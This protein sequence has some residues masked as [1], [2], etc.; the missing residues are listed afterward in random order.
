M[1]T[2]KLFLLI[3]ISIAI[4]SCKKGDKGDLGPQG[5]AGTTGATGA[6]GNANA[7][8]ETISISSSG[9]QHIG[10]QGQVGDGQEAIKSTSIITSDIV[11]GGAVLAF[12][13]TGNLIWTSLP[14][15]DYFAS[16]HETWSYVYETGQITVRIN[17][18]DFIT[19]SPASTVYLKVVVI[20][21][22]S[23]PAPGSGI[24]L[25]NY[26]QV[27]AYYHLTD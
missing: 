16:Y 14:T 11:S 18:S 26:E 24:D 22:H 8:T 10:T 19:L 23:R 21:G 17:D 6:T 3:A 4:V 9:W 20:A 13:S 2:I 25:R 27:K 15:T 5:P 7:N 12:I 1:K